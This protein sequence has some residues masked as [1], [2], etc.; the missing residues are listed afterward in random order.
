[1]LPTNCLF[2]TEPPVQDDLIAGGELLQSNRNVTPTWLSR[3]VA[4]L[5]A[6][7]LHVIQNSEVDAYIRSTTMWRLLRPD[8]TNVWKNPEALKRLRR[9]RGIIDM[10]RWAKYVLSKDIEC[11][12]DFTEPA[13]RLWEHH[14]DLSKQ[15]KWN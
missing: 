4:V 11:D 8:A 12:V 7:I 15:M 5:A 3:R 2:A 9:Y 10:G 6:S 1:M 14:A 13:E